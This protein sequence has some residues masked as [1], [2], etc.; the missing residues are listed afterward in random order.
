MSSVTTSAS[1]PNVIVFG[2]SA[3]GMNALKGIFE[4]FDQI[5]NS[6]V[7]VVLHRDPK[8]SPLAEV[9]QNYTT[10]PIREPDDS[11]WTPPEG[12]VAV[13]PAGYH[14]LLG[15]TRTL[16]SE[17]PTP[18]SLYENGT[19]VRTHLTLDPPVAYSRP[20]LNVTF[21]SA[22]ELVNPVT[23]VLLSCAND[24]GA[25]GCEVVKASGE[26]WCSRIRPRA[27]RPPRSTRRCA[28]CNRTSLP[29]RG[30]SVCGCRGTPLGAGDLRR[31]RPVPRRVC[32]KP[33]EWE[34]S[35][36]F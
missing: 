18:V 5:G 28:R 30:R 4:T 26:E 16:V 34:V 1:V 33:S 25:R 36:I 11:P 9:L 19:G 31:F 2:G 15:N 3:G 7:V 14:L 6:I 12:V 13:A 8:D 29:I 24:D 35:R 22:A 23:V 27:R 10:I 21:S 17:P 20:S 32:G